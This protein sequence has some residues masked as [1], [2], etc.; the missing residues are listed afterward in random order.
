MNTPND[1][2][3][4][5]AERLQ[6][7]LEEE[8]PKRER[9]LV[10]EHLA[11]CSRCGSELESWK[12]LF[13]GLGDLHGFRPH[14]G[15]T[16][17][18]MTQVNIPESSP[19]PVRVRARLAA[20]LGLGQTGHIDAGTAHDL[21]DGLLPGRQAARVRR[22]VE[23]CGACAHRMEG[24]AQVVRELDALPR[25][26]PSASFAEGVMARVHLARRTT[27]TPAKASTP[28]HG[29]MVA[30][31]KLLPRTRRAWA[32]LS[33]AAVTPAVTLGLVAYAVFS[34][35]AL[36]LGSLLSWMSWQIT[37]LAAAGWSA[38]M[39]ILAQGVGA[40]GLQGALEAATAAPV[41]IAG[42]AVAYSALVVLALR[43]LYK[44]LVTARPVGIGHAQISRS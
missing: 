1:N 30:A 14:E 26:A 20:F 10:E 35:P 29:W 37:D 11:S 42:V 31:R 13:S 15:F 8:L 27:A 44:N 34:H 38:G 22:H 43:V 25:L 16:E 9:R 7:F 19:L 18:V 40:L 39:G 6:A 28:A 32:A 24:V 21:V 5:S 36:T 17:R 33:G 3:H 2:R 41:A 12:A 4:P 23:S